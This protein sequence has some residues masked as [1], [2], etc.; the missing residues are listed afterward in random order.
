MKCP[1]C[2][3]ENP[4]DTRFCGRCGTQLPR[5]EEIS[6]SATKTLQASRKELTVGGTFA[7][8]YQV[9]EELGKGG[10]GRVYKV[11]DKE[12][13]EKVALKLLNPEIAADKQ[14][15]ERFRNELKL[16]R[17]ISHRNVCR[18]YDLSKEERTHFITMEYVSGEDLK[19][20][21]R[22]MGP[23]SAGK[24]I[25]IAK[26]VCEGLSEAHRLGVVHR[27]LKPQNIMI[28][29]EGN[30]RIMDFGI[31]RSLKAKGITDAGVMIGTPEYM[32]VEQVEGKKADQ[33]SDIYSLGIILYEMVT[34]R[35][36]FEGDT[37]L[38]IA[39]KHKTQAPPDPRKINAQIPEDLSRVILRCMEKDKEN[40]YEGAEELFSELSKIEKGIPTTER[41]LPKRKPSTSKEITVTFSLRK[42]FIPALALVAVAIVVVIIW[43]LIPQ[44]E[45]VS[46]PPGKPSLAIMYFENNTG[47]ESL[48]HWRK[49]IAD[50]LIT[51]LTQSK[52]VKVLSGDR[53][54]NIL[55][56]LDQLEAKSYSSDVL[57][58]VAGRG[59]VGHILLGNY[60]RAGENLRIDVMLQEASTGELLGSERV[61]A[62]GEE[63]IF[64]MVD[65]LTKRIKS[66]FKLSA[67]E[68][69]RDIDKAVGEITTNSPEA[70]KYYSEGRKYHLKGDYRHSIQLMERAVAIDSE[71]AMAYRSL[72]MSYGNLGYGSESRK[73]RQK[74][75]ELI[76]RVS[77]RERHLI[78]AQFYSQSEK[79]WGKTIK[80]YNNLLR[81]Y[82][83]DGIANNNLGVVYNN[84]EQWDKAIERF[85]VCIQNKDEAIYPYVNLASSSQATGLYDKAREV[86]EY[87]LNNISDNVSIRGDLAY[88][89]L[90]QGEYDLALVEVDK[91]LSLD[92][93]YYA[94]VW[95]KGDIYHC[96][97]DLTKAEK[98][99]QKLLEAE[100]K[101]AHLYGRRRLAALYLL[102][103]K[104]EKSK[105]QAQ[106]GIELAEKLGEKRWK[107]GFHVGLAYSYLKSGNPEK[108]L[109][110]CNKAWNIASEEEMF[111]SQRAALLWKGLTYL[112][113]KSV[114]EA[115]RTADELKEL[116]EKGMHRKIIRLHHHLMGMIELER[117]NFSKAIE[118]FNKALSLLP[119]QSSPFN[120]HALFI[121]PLALAYYKAGDLEKAREEYE[122]ITSLTTGRLSYGDIYARSFY[123]LG[124]IYQEKGWEGKA[125]EHYSRFIELW[126]D[127]DPGIPEVEDAKQRIA[128]LKSKV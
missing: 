97:G 64:S 105:S 70:Y 46:L 68:I 22:R 60:A 14:T 18:M 43:R 55:S 29:R 113:M 12:I 122:K 8:R 3:F 40:R 98:E 27:D 51:D 44:K 80:A 17:K 115:Q 73:Y 90:C 11:F 79:T 16:A 42:L 54:F 95:V 125:I 67:E 20:S 6:V 82:P 41:V 38:T 35:V 85:V 117:N 10:M 50:L 47:D 86:L 124:K 15:I 57:R 109:E 45:E 52:Y 7:G 62:I 94:N 92:T 89:Y 53:L 84:L 121:D 19:S 24:A 81:L 114:D 9:I 21:I 66:N 127:A 100:E 93:A 56:Q 23:L 61:E 36:P 37:P 104:F 120:A 78:Q 103:G 5:P 34:G 4:E 39:V 118:Y 32:S 1:K 128:Q 119:S 116:I 49:A 65:E 28:D 102:Q 88:N 101:T 108:A 30:A 106:K 63:S 48:D 77:D 76:D 112:E 71:F 75:F 91:A 99:Y 83:E 87:Y 13:K 26:Q 69:A 31:A 96:K 107:P 123:M 126:K 110:E 25:F 74:A 59:R 2:H 58:Q 72:A 111:G 33:R